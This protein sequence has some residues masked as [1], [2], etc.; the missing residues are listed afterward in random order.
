MNFDELV[1]KNFVL[2]D[3][4]S[5]KKIVELLI[6][7]RRGGSFD[8]LFKLAH[9]ASFEMDLMAGPAKRVG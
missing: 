6:G 1:L 5:K 4:T 3:Q 9:S 8:P 7:R 2:I